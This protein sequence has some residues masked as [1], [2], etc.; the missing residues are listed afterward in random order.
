[1]SEENS[2]TFEAWLSVTIPH[3]QNSADVRSSMQFDI[4]FDKHSPLNLTSG[5]A[6]TV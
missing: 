2:C 5:V 4:L 3:T 6:C 1:M